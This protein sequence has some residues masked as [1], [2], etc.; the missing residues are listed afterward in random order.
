MLPDPARLVGAAI[1]GVEVVAVGWACGI[2]TNLPVMKA[3]DE[4]SLRGAVEFDPS[5]LDAA[6]AL[7]QLLYRNGDT[8]GALELV[9]DARGHPR[10]E[11]LAA[12]I[13]LER[14]ADPEVLAA[15]TKLDEGR[16][17]AGLDQLIGLLADKGPDAD[18][19][20]GVIVA[21]LDQ[22][23]SEHPLARETRRKLGDALN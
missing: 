4:E 10:A 7:A 13:E 9:K 3:T 14:S 19:I 5:N 8:G 1:D 18:R 20:R 2:E 21:L 11:G 16:L 17:E 23:G 22:L 6:F 12:R 15:L